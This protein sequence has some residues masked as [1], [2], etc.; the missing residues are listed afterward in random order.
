MGLEEVGLAVWARVVK[1]SQLLWGP[2][3]VLVKD[4]HCIWV[5]WFQILACFSFFWSVTLDKGL[6]FSE[7]QFLHL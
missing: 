6:T 7:P 3:N 1:D 5:A 4:R 2:Q